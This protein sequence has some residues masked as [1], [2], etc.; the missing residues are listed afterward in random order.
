MMIIRYVATVTAMREKAS[1]N[2]LLYRSCALWMSTKYMSI[3]VM[4]VGKIA[5]ISMNLVGSIWRVRY[6]WTSIA[7]LRPRNPCC[8]STKVEFR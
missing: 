2:F 5:S 6:N 4:A 3:K 7:P 8:K 1:R